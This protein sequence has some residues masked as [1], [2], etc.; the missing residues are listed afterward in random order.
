MSSSK[1]LKGGRASHVTVSPYDIKDMGL[2]GKLT[3]A[4]K[5]RK[6]ADEILRKAKSEKESIEL[7]AYKQGFSQ[8][9]KEG[10][11]V[12]VK[13]IN[14]LFNTFS[15]AVEEIAGMRQNIIQRHHDQILELVVLITEKI[16]HRAIHISPEIVLDTVS[17]ASKYLMKTDEIR[18][19]LHPSDYEYIKDIEKLLSVNLTGKKNIDFVE[20]SSIDRGGV[21]IETEFGEIDATIRSQIDHIKETLFEHD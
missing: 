4:E 14:P 1:I 3:I 7:K 13:K 9:Q 5:A 19:R 16:L 18:L 15:A 20:D 6:E 8:G 21:I 10:K 12:A 2:R 17:A 11:K